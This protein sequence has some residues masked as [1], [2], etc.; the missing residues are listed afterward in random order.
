VAFG[1]TI[2]YYLNTFSGHL[3][4]SQSIP[5]TPHSNPCGR[6]LPTCI[7]SFHCTA[8]VTNLYPMNLKCI[9][10]KWVFHHRFWCPT[11]QLC[12]HWFDP[13]WW[14]PTLCMSSPW[15][16]PYASIKSCLV[17][18]LRLLVVPLRTGYLSLVRSS[19]HSSC[20]AKG[21]P[22][23]IKAFKRTSVQ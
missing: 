21:H 8:A 3:I 20:W 6:R 7:K 19:H 2:S 14:F 22:A 1:L 9:M 13:H 15:S 16:I 11:T 10:W 17:N 4:W 12:C 23:L 5:Y 18:G